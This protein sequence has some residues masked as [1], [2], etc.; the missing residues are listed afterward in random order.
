[1]NDELINAYVALINQ[2]NQFHLARADSQTIVADR[3][4]TYVFNTYFHTRLVTSGYDYPGVARWTRRAG[5]DIAEKDLIL[6]PVNLGNNHWVLAGIDILRQ[7]FLYLDSM[8]GRDRAGVVSSLKQWIYDEV[9]DKHGLAAA[10]ALGVD[11][12][13]VLC[14]QYLPFQRQG[15]D[16][17]GDSNTNVH[18]SSSTQRIPMQRD[19]GSCGVFTTMIA[20]CL[21]M[22]IR[23]Y[24]NHQHIKLIRSRMALDLYRRILPG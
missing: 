7:T 9:H 18:Q 6:I 16:A 12:W 19:S 10:N 14:N 11:A 20:N 3:P 13:T 23:V 22:G 8:H 2:R 21:E 1:L 4:R 5:V 15:S 17:K 24:F